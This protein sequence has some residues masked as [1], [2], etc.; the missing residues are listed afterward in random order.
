MVAITGLTLL[1]A[2]SCQCTQAHGWLP[3]NSSI[4]LARGNEKQLPVY[5]L[6]DCSDAHLDMD[7][8]QL[9]PL[10]PPLTHKP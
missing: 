9:Y 3:L 7:E 4:Q 6:G 10:Q 2:L 1:Q 5:M 8:M